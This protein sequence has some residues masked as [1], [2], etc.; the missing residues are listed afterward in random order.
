MFGNID[1]AQCP[2]AEH[3]KL[4]FVELRIIVVSFFSKDGLIK[5]MLQ[6]LFLPW[7]T[8]L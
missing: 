6:I 8:R 5:Q 3:Q 4:S 2:E 7:N 1:I